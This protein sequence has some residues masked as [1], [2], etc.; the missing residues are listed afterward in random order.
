MK[1]F[2]LEIE[3]AKQ[4]IIESKRQRWIKGNNHNRDFIP[5]KAWFIAQWETGFVVCD[6]EELEKLPKRKR[7]KILSLGGLK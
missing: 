4:E 2:K 5:P 1:D 3:K 6:Y 7:E